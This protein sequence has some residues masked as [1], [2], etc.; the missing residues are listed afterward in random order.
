[1][2]FST[3]FIEWY[4]QGATWGQ[5]L[6]PPDPGARGTI[7]GLLLQIAGTSAGSALLAQYSA[8]NTLKIGFGPINQAQYATV[9]GWKA[10]S[11]DWLGVDYNINSQGKWVVSADV[12]I[13]AHEL[14]HLV[15]SGFHPDP[16]TDSAHLNQ[17]GYDYDGFPT[18]QQN[19]VATQL[20]LDKQISYGS[21]ISS[22]RLLQEGF[23]VGKSYS[24]NQQIDAV[25]FATEGSTFIGERIDT[26]NSPNG[27]AASRD[28]VFALNGP[29]LITTG[30]G[31]D[32]VYGGAGNDTID[33]GD[34]A[35]RL[36]GEIG[37]D[38]L[39]G[40]AGN[41][42]LYG[43]GLSGLS[44]WMDDGSDTLQG[45]QG[46][47][48]L[49]IQ[50]GSDSLSGD[51]GDDLLDIRSLDAKAADVISVRMA[52]GGGH[53]YLIF[54]PDDS[55]TQKIRIILTDYTIGQVTFLSDQVL[56]PHTP[57]DDEWFSEGELVIVLPDGTSLFLGALHGT[58]ITPGGPISSGSFTGDADIEF[59]FSG[60]VTRELNSVF[61]GSGGPATL[62]VGALDSNHKDAL[63]NW[64]NV[65]PPP[66]TPATSPLSLTGGSSD[67][68]LY[69]GNADDV[70]AA[71]PANNQML[72]GKGDDEYRWQ[73]GNGDIAVQDN[74]R[75]PGD[76]LQLTGVA[77]TAVS[78]S[79]VDDDVVM[80]IAP[81]T[82]GGADGGE[83][84]L[85][86]LF[87]GVDDVGVDSVV[88]SDVT[89]SAAHI[90]QVIL[91][92]PTPGPDTLQ[93]GDNPDTLAGG[94]GDDWLDGGSGNDVFTWARGDGNDAI[95]DW[96]GDDGD[97]LALSG[98][99]ASSVRLQAVSPY[100]AILIVDP[101]SPGGSDGGTIELRSVLADGNDGVDE[102]AFSGGVVWSR[103]DFL[104]HLQIA[105]GTAGADNIYGGPGDD[106]LSGLG[107]ADTVSGGGGNDTI[108]WSRGDGDDVLSDDGYNEA[109][110]LV[111]H[112][113]L[114]QDVTF[115]SE[116]GNLVLIIA[117]SGPGAGDGGS[118]TLIDSVG[119][120]GGNGIEEVHFDN[121]VI[122]TK[123]DFQAGVLAAS[124]TPGNDTIQGFQGGET[125]TGGTGD[126]LIDGGLGDDVFRW[127]AGDG[128][129][130]LTEGQECGD[131]RLELVGISPGDVTVEQV[132]DDIH[133]I[134]DQAGGP[135]TLILVNQAL[136]DDDFGIE[137]IV[138]DG[139]TWTA[140][141]LMDQLAG[142]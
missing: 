10:I 55:H 26:A 46:N 127:S 42:R 113:V 111:L 44:R 116:D 32:H 138:L 51:A 140:E 19:L 118:I 108:V 24:D 25:R 1:M 37:D 117:P 92:T 123:A 78:L 141:D 106:T 81:S 62:Q 135:T 83:I 30:A 99:S 48:L 13:I 126:D 72:G 122:W 76:V 110:H 85:Q 41:D 47:D 15:G 38:L 91:S 73:R 12:L 70:L 139:Q 52:Q 18:T 16:E 57:Q 2:S 49:T 5:N 98:I 6:S 59:V 65:Q 134:I 95:D 39:I 7:E 87:S 90:R 121:A 84:K 40:G 132:G 67:G 63:A 102:I 128:N 4:A 107:G 137:T 115:G 29:S 36:V 33:S 60:G 56:K 69:G 101:S 14:A 28:L 103:A 9:A 125:I 79:R 142:A 133:L 109:D 23:V 94:A 136:W 88:F 119:D 34:G 43:G 68:V 89:W 82:P 58:S 27:N 93:G 20:S 8:T 21:G 31:D 64:P 104:T 53:D 100:D 74:A 97:R 3:S 66:A 114:P 77:S 50:R 22:A 61:T 80:T 131:D 105:P 112:G 124:Q 17:S 130:V 129:D 35:D 96:G 86:D 75:D 45:G 71:G 120:F 11:L 54:S